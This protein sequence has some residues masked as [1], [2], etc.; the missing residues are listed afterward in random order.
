MGVLSTYFPRGDSQHHLVHQGYRTFTESAPSFSAW[1]GTL[2]DHPITR[3][4]IERFAVACSKLKPEVVGSDNC[5][6]TVRKLFKT[7]PN[8][9]M[10]WPAFLQRCATIFEMDTTLFIVPGL[11]RNLNVVA[12]FPM[13]PSYTEI[14]EYEGVPWCVFHLV[15]GDV[16][17]MELFRCAVVSKFQYWSD[18]FG[19]GNDVMAPTMALLDAQRQAEMQAVQNGARIRFIGRVVGMTHGDDLKR[20]REAFFEDNLSRANMTGLML[21]DNTFDNIEQVDEKRFTIDKDEMDRV[22]KPVYY[23]FGTNEAIL[24]NDF[25]ED[26]WGAWYESKIE[27]FALQLG[28]SITKATYTANEVVRGNG[29]MFSSSRLEYAS[30]KTKLQVIKELGGMGILNVNQALEIMQMPGIAGGEAR[31]VRGEYY[32]L[33]SENNVIAE[34]GGHNSADDPSHGGTW[35]DEPDDYWDEP[36]DGHSS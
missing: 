31:I 33:D 16:V 35:A 32:L 26:Q 27:P 13:K 11:D 5:K 19:A 30:N 4:A 15:T 36:D 7:W 34:S 24:T 20:K 29:V 3:A 9:L 21:Y 14:V 1:D 25:D 18:I 8:E 2:Y 10:T 22:T 17:A 28:E 12:L 6:P 23:Y